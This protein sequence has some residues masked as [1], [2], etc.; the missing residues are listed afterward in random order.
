MVGVALIV[1]VLLCC[2]SCVLCHYFVC[3]S[4]RI[5]HVELEW[6]GDVD[7]CQNELLGPNFC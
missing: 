4:R 3:C 7:E 6:H 1:S 2:I 5:E